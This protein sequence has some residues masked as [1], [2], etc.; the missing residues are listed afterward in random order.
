MF[1]LC[2]EMETST[3][4]RKCAP[5]ISCNFAGGTRREKTYHTKSSWGCA[6]AISSSDKH[7][8][9]VAQTKASVARCCS[10][11][12]F[13]TTQ[14]CT[15]PFWE[16]NTRGHACLRSIPPWPR[17]LWLPQPWRQHPFHQWDPRWSH[18]PPTL[19]QTPSPLL[20][21]PA[22]TWP[23]PMHIR[24]PPVYK[25]LPSCPMP[26]DWPVKQ[27]L[28]LDNLRSKRRGKKKQK[29]QICPNWSGNTCAGTCEGEEM[30]VF[31][32]S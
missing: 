18:H 20:R 7:Y 5:R 25:W 10:T 23:S 12:P 22:W 3:R 11:R 21:R 24:G 13:A 27:S 4:S 28:L 16:S 32:K 15:W 31:R 6:A 2:K 26:G 1:P 29:K 14:S 8:I 19:Q 30:H 17:P 9:E